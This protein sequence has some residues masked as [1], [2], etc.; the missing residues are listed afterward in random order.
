M[1]RRS[2][3]ELGRVTN[4]WQRDAGMSTRGQSFVPPFEQVK[5]PRS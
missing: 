5:R 1:T 4:M 2:G 3:T